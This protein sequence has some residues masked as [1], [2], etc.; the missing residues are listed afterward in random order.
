MREILCKMIGHTVNTEAALT[1]KEAYKCP[2]CGEKI[3]PIPEKLL[4][5]EAL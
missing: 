5:L 2:R 3:M 1:E 4:E